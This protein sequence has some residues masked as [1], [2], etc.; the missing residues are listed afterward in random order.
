MLL[1]LRVKDYALISELEVEF[2]PGL[3]I[4]TGETGAGKS[5]LV[6]ALKLIL[7]ERAAKEFIRSGAR[8][9][10]VEGEFAYSK[11]SGISE[12]LERNELE[13]WPSLIIRREISASSGRVFVN[14]SP[15]SLATLKD[16]SS[17]LIDLHGQHDNQSL[18]RSDSH[19]QLLDGYAGLVQDVEEY[20]KTFDWLQS[21]MSRKRH[22]ISRRSELEQKKDLYAFQLKEIDEVGP[23]NDEEDT[24]R[25][26][27]KILDNVELIASTSSSATEALTQGQQSI[28]DRLVDVRKRVEKISDLDVK[29][30]EIYKEL[31]SAEISIRESANLLDEFLSGM[32]LDDERVEFVR[33][34]LGDLEMLKRKYGG[35]VASVLAHREMV[36]G[37][38][39]QT[40][41]IDKDLED[42]DRQIEAGKASLSEK[43]N[44]L[45]QKR[46]VAAKKMEAELVSELA[47]LGIGEADLVVRFKIE[48]KDNGMISTSEGP[49]VAQSSG[50]DLVEFFISTNKGEPVKALTKVASG[51]E[52]SRI[53]LAF[54]SILARQEHLPILF[55]D[56]IDT[57]ISG[58]IAHKVGTSMRTLAKRHQIM[59]ITHLPQIA[60]HG[61]HHYLVQKEE[62][63]GRSE[64]QINYLSEA[65]RE[66]AL[67]QLI[68][69]EQI[70][71][72]AL[73]GA[74]EMLNKSNT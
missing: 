30:E 17:R 38:V 69:G 22:L 49:V 5:I 27:V 56:E 3:N 43:A 39:L 51:G 15:T 45:S 34:R 53:M 58:Q 59:A 57:G 47:G 25:D 64:T 46:R 40:D 4:I 8:K 29:L 7:G 65:E 20:R 36:S 24:L 42:L 33:Q 70:S 50:M 55:F 41:N 37:E 9:S 16:I 21:A 54:K 10:I 67:A 28:Y 23:Q 35:S 73:S 52:V 48:K 60:A 63:E 61:H 66:R 6:G 12:I 1:T 2:K 14:D 68:S 26:E 18:L 44:T 72:A 13:E 71:D 11:G 32:D 62:S 31:Q 19:I 74:R